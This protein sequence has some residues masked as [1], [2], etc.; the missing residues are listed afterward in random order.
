MWTRAAQNDL[1][2]VW[3]AADDRQAVTAASRL[4]DLALEADPLTVGEARTASVN[5]FAVISGL[6]VWFEVI[7]DDYRVIVHAVSR[8]G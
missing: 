3:L 1:A 5:R 8:A 7:V 4:T 6:A 2:A